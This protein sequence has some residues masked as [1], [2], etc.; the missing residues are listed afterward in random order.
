MISVF[1]FNDYREF[2]KTY[3]DELGSNGY[4]WKGKLASAL[5]ISSSLVSQI[6]AGQKSLTQEQTSDLCDFLGFN[7][8]ESDCLHTLV[9]LDRSGHFKYQQKLKSRLQKIKSQSKKIGQRVPR[10]KELNEEQKAIYYSNWLP[11]GVR[12][13]CA[14]PNIKTLE[15]VAKHLGLEVHTL[16][17]VFEFLLEMGLIKW[18]DDQITYATASTHVDR[19][20]PFVGL[21]HRNWRL[22]ALEKINLKKN[23][24]VFFTGPM[25]LSHQAYEEIFSYIPNFIQKVMDTSAP[26]DSEM[27]ACL[28]IDWFDF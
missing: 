28:N 6:F 18:Q 27:T 3:H 17:E 13:L 1:E 10:S 14:L 19:E 23:E 5:G 21:H 20:S 15:D 7:E 26:S 9:D 12:N 4:G 16:R 25:S 2:L 24:H 8:L 22:Q 11:T